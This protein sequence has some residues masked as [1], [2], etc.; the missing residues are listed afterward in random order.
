MSSFQ[1]ILL[2]GHR[3]GHFFVVIIF[4]VKHAMIRPPNYAAQDHRMLASAIH[5]WH[6][7]LK[8]FS[9][10]SAASLPPAKRLAPLTGT[11]QQH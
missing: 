7:V 5:E 3:A 6:R 2:P 1:L 10:E 8:E 9:A 11:A 4:A